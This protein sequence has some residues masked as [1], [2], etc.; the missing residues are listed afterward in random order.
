MV[1]GIVLF[2]VRFQ[3]VARLVA[4]HDLLLILQLLLKTLMQHQVALM[5]RSGRPV[6]VVCVL[7]E[8]LME[9]LGL[10]IVYEALGRHLASL[11]KVFNASGIVLVLIH[12]A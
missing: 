8:H 5:V 1:A 2:D 9:E 10:I 11:V 6:V 4:I 3:S 12:Q 7:C